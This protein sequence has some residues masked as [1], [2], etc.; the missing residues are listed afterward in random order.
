MSLKKSIDTFDLVFE[1]LIHYQLSPSSFFVKYI[2]F[3]R[4]H[5]KLNYV[6]FKCHGSGTQSEF[7]LQNYTFS[8]IHV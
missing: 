3:Y 8:V 7:Y 2:S 6:T 1:G 5:L 4:F